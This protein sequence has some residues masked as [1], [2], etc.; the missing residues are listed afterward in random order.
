MASQQ[1]RGSGV[2]CWIKKTIR[3]D[4]AQ[5]RIGPLGWMRHRLSVPHSFRATGF[6]YG[7][8]GSIFVGVW[9]FSSLLMIIKSGENLSLSLSCACSAHSQNQS[10]L[11]IGAYCACSTCF[12]RGESLVL[13]PRRKGQLR[14]F[15]WVQRE[16]S[17]A[18]WHKF[19]PGSL[20]PSSSPYMSGGAFLSIS[21]C[22][23]RQLLHHWP[24]FL[25]RG[26]LSSCIH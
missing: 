6:V 12:G 4:V 5:S 9:K 24:V 25:W 19:S 26:C 20:K 8:V 2:W 21:R 18:A 1:L 16:L 22:I 23:P 11:H 14:F 17:V 15:F 13:S 7:G 10:I 3:H